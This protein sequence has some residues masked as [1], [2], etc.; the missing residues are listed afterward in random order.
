[1]RFLVFQHLAVEH[2]GVFRDFFVEAGIE[3]DVVELD[4]GQPIPDLNDYDALWVMGGPMD[5]WEVDDHPWLVAEKAAI[6]EAVNDRGMPFLGCCLGHQLLA[7]ALGGV[8]A[9]FSKQNAFSKNAY[10]WRTCKPKTTKV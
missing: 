3:W 2:P 8:C 10:M 1:M 4:E 6:R 9:K 7:N 5:V